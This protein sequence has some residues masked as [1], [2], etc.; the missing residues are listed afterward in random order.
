MIMDRYLARSV[1]LPTITVLALLVVLNSVYRFIDEQGSVREGSYSSLQALQFVALTMPQQLFDMMPAAVLLGAMVGLGELA[2]GSEITAF[3]AAGVSVA[4]IGLSVGAVSMLLLLLT[5]FI[6]EYVAPQAAAIARRQRAT[7]LT[8][9]SGGLQGTNVWLREGRK[10]I[11]VDARAGAHVAPD[12][13]TLEVSPE[14]DRL[15]AVGHADDVTVDPEGTW[16]MRGYR[17]FTY[18]DGGIKLVIEPQARLETRAGMFLTDVAV[19]PDDRSMTELIALR[20]HLRSNGQ[21]AHSFEFALWSRGARTVA[22]VFCAL[23]ALPFA[24]G[25]MRTAG[26]GKRIVIAIGIGFAFILAQQIVESGAVLTTLPPALL[27]CLP[28]LLL[29]TVTALLLWRLRR[30]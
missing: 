19:E 24:F 30:V 29:G 26:A 25:G 13:T 15:M 17:R 27:A 7:A 3:R 11:R 16:R 8:D 21:D 6:S 2:R 14:G 5:A 20:R 10:F 9:H 22:I 1:V 28:T 4:R 12:L 18:G 23:L